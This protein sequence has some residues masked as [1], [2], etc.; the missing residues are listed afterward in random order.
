MSQQLPPDL[1]SIKTEFPGST[2]DPEPR[3]SSPH[4]RSGLSGPAMHT[5][6]P[7]TSAAGASASSSPALPVPPQ[8]QQPPG[9]QSQVQQPPQGQPQSRQLQQ[10]HLMGGPPKD[11]SPA[12]QL[13]QLAAQQQAAQQQ[14]AQMMQSQ[15]QVQK[16]QQ[17]QQHQR[18]QQ[19]QQQQQQSQQAAKFPGHPNHPSSWSQAAPPTQS[20][21]GGSVYGLDKPTSPSLYQQDFPNPKAMLMPGQPPNKGSPK[22]GTAGGYM[23]APGAHPGMLG[24]PGQGGM[25]HP[26]GPGGPQSSMPD[27]SNTKPLTHFETAGGPMGGPQGPGS[28]S[29]AANQ[30]A[31]LLHMMRQQQQQQH[32]KQK[33]AGLPF[34]APPHMQHPQVSYRLWLLYVQGCVSH[35]CHC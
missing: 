24:H 4:M 17:Q 5:S 35:Q 34:R 16:Q 30:K 12:Q 10:N 20:P 29:A 3:T 9:P 14:R 19:Q 13:K 31:A 33:A 2:F 23:G 6:S 32:M 8:Q 15:Q 25:G 18:K 26:Q 27:Y 7:N 28:A 21:L 22:A 11:L 1:A